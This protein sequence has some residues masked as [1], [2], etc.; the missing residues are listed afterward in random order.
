MDKIR[1]CWLEFWQ[2]PLVCCQIRLDPRGVAREWES[3]TTMRK[4]LV[5]AVIFIAIAT[6][7]AV[8]AAGA[9]GAVGAQTTISDGIFWG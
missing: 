4:R 9:A 8:G 7:V 6:G 2:H 3:G 5:R 1:C